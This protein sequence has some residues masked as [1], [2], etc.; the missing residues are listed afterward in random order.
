[1]LCAVDA[2]V[3]QH[4]E[5]LVTLGPRVILTGIARITGAGVL[6]VLQGLNTI[7]AEP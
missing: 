4:W 2:S 5:T 6:L 3:S 7:N 1:M